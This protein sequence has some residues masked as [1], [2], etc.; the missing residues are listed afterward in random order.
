M[1]FLLNFLKFRDFSSSKE[2]SATVKRELKRV[3]RTEGG[4]QKAC[5]G[6]GAQAP[7]EWGWSPRFP[8][9]DTGKQEHAGG[10]S[11]KPLVVAGVPRRSLRRRGARRAWPVEQA[12]AWHTGSLGTVPRVPP[13]PGRRHVPLLA[14]VL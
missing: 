11:Q 9:P 2:V 13:L 1:F 6:V 7:E 12:G 8:A 3:L 5:L 10:G 4:A 14:S